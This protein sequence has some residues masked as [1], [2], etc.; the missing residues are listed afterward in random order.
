MFL[1]QTHKDDPRHALQL[2]FALASRGVPF[3]IHT[4]EQGDH[5]WGLYD[6]GDPD[7]PLVP[8]TKLWGEIAADW[9]VMRGF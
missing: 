1:F 7:S 3:E 4:F 6:G 8:H 9:L 5:G 2:G